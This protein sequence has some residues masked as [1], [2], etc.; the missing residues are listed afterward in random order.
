MSSKGNPYRRHDS[1]NQ[2]YRRALKLSGIHGLRFHDLRHTAATRMIE[3]G[4]NIVSVNKILRH[5]DLK[6]TMRY[7]HPDD[8]LK[9]A[10]E[11]LSSY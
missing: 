8:S 3:A 2:M 4:V 7:L 10:V 6:T 1:L 5:A 9:D 11:S